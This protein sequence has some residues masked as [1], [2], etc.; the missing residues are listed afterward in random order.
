VRLLLRKAQLALEDGAVADAFKYA[1]EAERL[2]GRQGEVA[3]LL[4]K[5]EQARQAVEEVRR[6]LEAALAS[7]H[8][9]SARKELAELTR[10][11]PR[12]VGL[13]GKTLEQFKAE[14]EARLAVAETILRRARA[15]KESAH[16]GRR[17]RV[18]RGARR[19]G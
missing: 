14:V 17:P 2:W 16:G 12:Y 7:K 6:R 11:A 18:P 4:G 15:R 9:F 5:V 13:D 3:S 1:R 10:A 19:G 8:L